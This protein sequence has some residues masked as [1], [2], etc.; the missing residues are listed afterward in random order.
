M[1]EHYENY[2]MDEM[3]ID[4]IDFLFYL[5]RR[6][7][8]LVAMIL[9]GAVLGSAFY[10]VKTTKS[11]NAAVEDYQPDADTEANM[12]L[13]AQYWK[14]Y[15]QQMDYNEHSIVMQM[16]PNQVYEGTLT[17][18]LA[19]GEQTERLAQ[20]F[21]DIVN[22]PA[23][24]E[25]LKETAGL[26]C[27][28]Q[29]VKEL[30]S[31]TMSQ[32]NV[33]ESS[34]L[35]A[36]VVNNLQ[37]TVPVDS[38][39]NTVI[40]YQVAYLSQETCEKMVAVLQDAVASATQ[41]YVDTYGEYEFDQLQNVVAVTVD[42]KYLEK[43]KTSAALVNNYLTKLAELEDAFDDTEMDYYQTVYL[44]NDSTFNA[45]EQV[46]QKNISLKAMCK[47]LLVGIVAF[48]FIWGTLQLAKYLT[49]SVIKTLDEV[50]KMKLP[51]I[52]YVRNEKAHMSILDRMEQK[53]NDISDSTDYIAATI[54]AF[55]EQQILLCGDL[56]NVWEQQ[57]LD[58]IQKRT[59]NLAITD[60]I[61]EDIT[62]LKN[63]K[64]S[65]G[66]IFAINLRKTSIK[67]LQK[68]LDVCKLQKITVLGVVVIENID[69]EEGEDG[70]S[71]V[72]K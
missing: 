12:K 52:G 7:K 38:I 22:D 25:E 13:A 14:L 56:N 67:Q 31:S 8:S 48:A 32:K 47:W 44:S 70:F 6:W 39:S 71:L 5:L 30:V 23:V 63:A 46:A 15:D 62:A 21:T 53:K 27:K 43:Q 28:D 19:A 11:S 50:K 37:V 34:D 41:K 60:W 2:D 26:D 9:L 35:T 36:N 20:L 69:T 24:L 1:N 66:V 72:N 49:D 42:E 57:M 58:E 55:P 16:D 3:E 4:L 40:T 59:S 18:Y 45:Q 61:H 68:A 65:D 54:N 29:Y 51:V 33:D 17:Y 10:V 64:K